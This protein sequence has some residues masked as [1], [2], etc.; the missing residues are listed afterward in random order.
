MT[1]TIEEKQLATPYFVLRG[2]PGEVQCF[3]FPS[4]LQNDTAPLSDALLSGDSAGFAIIWSLKINRPKAIWKAHEKALLTIESWGN[5]ILTH[6]RDN[7]LYLWEILDMDDLMGDLPISLAEMEGTTSRQKPFMVCCVDVNSLNFCQVALSLPISSEDRNSQRETLIAVPGLIGSEYID[8][9]ALPSTLRLA[10][11][12]IATQPN[13]GKLG[14]VMSIDFRYPRMA[15]AYENGAVALFEVDVS[16]VD[17]SSQKQDG[18]WR[19]LKVW[20]AHRDAGLS[21]VLHPETG[22]LYSCGIDA[23]LV[24]YH[25]KDR[26]DESKDNYEELS[27]KHSGQQS[28]RLRSDGKLLGTAGWDSHARIYTTSKMKQVAV[29]A[30]HKSALNAFAFRDIAGSNDHLVA[31]GGKDGKISLWKIF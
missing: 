9:Y 17:R 13:K 28:M 30:H 6:G 14:N 10:T 22:V 29:L 21:V 31:L 4:V 1:L 23:K 15:T 19:C 8:I 26:D 5:H 20:T 12:I 18:K 16:H 2:H 24:S 11:R 7:K 3:H 25:Y 27:T